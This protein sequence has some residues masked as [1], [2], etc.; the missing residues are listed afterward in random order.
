[1]ALSWFNRKFSGR[2]W[3]LFPGIC[4]LHSVS[5][6]LPYWPSQIS[7]I[8]FDTRTQRIIQCWR[9]ARLHRPFLGRTA[10]STWRFHFH[11]SLNSSDTDNFLSY[12]E[13]ISAN[14][15][16]VGRFNGRFV[17]GWRRN[18]GNNT[19]MG[20]SIIILLSGFPEEITARNWSNRWQASSAVGRWSR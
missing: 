15:F 10:A 7:D 13:P 12:N 3:E 4:P 5:Q 6:A 11:W 19:E 1:M 18:D 8:G 17:C 14:R 2:N 16:A 9:S 20:D